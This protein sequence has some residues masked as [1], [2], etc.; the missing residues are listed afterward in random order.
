MNGTRINARRDEAIAYTSEPD[1]A[2]ERARNGLMRY[3][4]DEQAQMFIACPTP[5]IRRH[6]I[7]N[8]PI[9]SDDRFWTH[10]S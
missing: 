6:T 4:L 10:I 5:S 9:C 3:S 7:P 2:A 1:D 8:D